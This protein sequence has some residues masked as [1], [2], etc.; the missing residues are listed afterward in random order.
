[1]VRFGIDVFG[2]GTSLG[3]ATIAVETAATRRRPDAV[4]S[5]NRWMRRDLGLGGW[6]TC[7]RL[8]TKYIVYSISR[9]FLGGCDYCGLVLG[10]PLY[11][12]PLS[13]LPGDF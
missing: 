6:G 7:V 9:V 2:A 5:G 10:G 8:F 13:I 11:I 4:F 12:R 3:R 1:M